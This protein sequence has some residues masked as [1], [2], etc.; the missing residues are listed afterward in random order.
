[1]SL[2]FADK[3]STRAYSEHYYQKQIKYRNVL[4][5]SLHYRTSIYFKSGQVYYKSGQLQLLQIGADLLQIGAVITNRGRF[6]TNRGRYYK[7]GQLLQIGA[8]HL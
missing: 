1:M 7:S 2:L 4:N 3:S 8:E 6:I 5:K